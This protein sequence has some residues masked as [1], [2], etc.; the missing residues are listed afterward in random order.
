MKRTLC[1]ILALSFVFTLS[2]MAFT[3]EHP[4]RD[5]LF[6]PEVIEQEKV[7]EWAKEEI[8]KAIDAGLVTEHTSDYMTKDITRFLYP[9]SF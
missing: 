7:S 5:D 8:D 3:F 9:V 6:S 2:S 1:A 4:D